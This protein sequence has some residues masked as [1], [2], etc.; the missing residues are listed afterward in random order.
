MPNNKKAVSLFRVLFI[1]YSLLIIF[2]MFISFHRTDMADFN[3]YRL[4]LEI[5]SIPLWMPKK[6]SMLWIF[7]IGNVLA[8]APFGVLLPESFPQLFRSYWRS[9]AAFFAAIIFLEFMQ[10]VTVLGSFDVEDILVNFL[11]FT[12]GFT[13]WRQGR[14]AD[15]FFKS[16]LIFIACIF[17]MTIALLFCAEFINKFL[18]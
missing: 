11:G 2:F 18:L 6:I 14:K 15:N 16:I 7:S 4:S 10:M 5:N 9:A 3:T 8:F 12:I 13:A 1:I 17:L